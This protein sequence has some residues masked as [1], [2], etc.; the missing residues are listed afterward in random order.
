MQSG[1]TGIN[2]VRIYNPIKQSMD[3]DP[4][5]E[6]IRRWV[7]E[8]SNVTAMWIH[9]PVKMSDQMQRLFGCVLGVDYPAPIVE[10]K[11][12]VQAARQR[13]FQVKKTKGFQESALK[14][15][16]KLGSR[17]SRSNRKK[18]TG[19]GQ[20]KYKQLSFFEKL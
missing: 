15:Y 10:H 7:P 3:H 8:L 9:E 4:T 16:L 12:A 13:I 17:K 1:I 2:T 5:G 11:T 14:V 18:T 6:F 20:S 19:L